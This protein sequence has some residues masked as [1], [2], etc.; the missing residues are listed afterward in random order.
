M[1]V[2]LAISDNAENNPARSG[3]VSGTY[4]L[5][6]T[7]NVPT[8]QLFNQQI[9]FCA[10]GQEIAIRACCGDAKWAKWSKIKITI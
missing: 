4:A 7:V 8:P 10:G 6:L 9:A 5:I 3:V 1:S 2:C